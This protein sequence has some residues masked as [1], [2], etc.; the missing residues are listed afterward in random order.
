MLNYL[1]SIKFYILALSFLLTVGCTPSPVSEE[2][3]L[4]GKTMGTTYSIKFVT[5]KPV[6]QTQ[7]QAGIDASL[8]KVNQQ[9]STYIKDSELSRFNQLASTEPIAVSKE[10][11]KVIG[12]GIRLGE[13]TAGKLDITVGPLVN[14]WGFGGF[15]PNSRPETIPS[16]EQIVRAKS[17]IGYHKLNLIDGKLSKSQAQLYVDL[18]TIAKG[19]GVDVVANLLEQQKITNYLVEI[20]GEMRLSGVKAN[21]QPWRVAVEKPV[22]GERAVQVVFSPGKNAVATSGDYRN[23]YEENGVRY[24]HII[25]TDTG[26][27]INHKLVSVTVVHPSSMTA[28][29]LSTA[30]MTLGTEQGKKFAEQHQLAVYMITKTATGFEEFMSEQ[31]KPYIK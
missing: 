3:L 16:D 28:D 30:L 25:D 24:S 27:P 21:G 9:M 20:G 4:T 19:Y 29:G 12:E 14:L 5:D 8:A 31:F 11:A 18:S 23:Y 26:Y 17:L 7:L 22:S 10:L 6:K 1:V 13:L 2:V 15:G